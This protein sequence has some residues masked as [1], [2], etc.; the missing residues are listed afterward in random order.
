MAREISSKNFTVR[1]SDCDNMSRLRLSSLFEFLEETAIVDAEQ[2]GFGIWKMRE[3]GYTYAVS[4]MKLRVNHVPRWGETL[5]VRTWTKD[6]FAHKVALKDYSVFDGSGKAI[7]QATSS[8]LLVN[9]RTGKSEDPEKA[10]FLP[11][12]FPE[13]NALSETLDILATPPDPKV[14]LTK[15]ARYADLDMNGHVNNCR[16]VDWAM[17]ALS[18]E[19]LKK[20]PLR[21]LQINY[22][23]QVPFGASVNLV[24]F[25]DSRHHAYIFG[26]SAS[27]PSAVHFQTRI[28]FSGDA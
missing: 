6:F 15:E 19:E 18:L 25:A 7:A 21:S 23:A 28:G 1:F 5:T 3:L 11:E 26:V 20:R 8:W 24:R 14:V 16:Y 10:P 13:E 9:L 4:R 17:D 2:N 27:D 12:L 22:L